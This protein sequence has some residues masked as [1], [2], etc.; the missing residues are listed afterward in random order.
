MRDL[1]V[2]DTSCLIALNK[3]ELLDILCKLYEK[4]FLPHMVIQEFGGK[5]D[6][7]CVEVIRAESPLRS[8]L[9]G[10]L[11]L[12]NGEAETIAYGYEKKV[13]IVIDDLKA[14]KVAEKLGLKVTGT[15]GILYKAQK[16]G[17]ITSAYK[18]TVKLKRKGFRV[19]DEILSKLKE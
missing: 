15:I 18:E 6:L 5:P 16:R 12:G 1:A 7:N 11:N 13:R 4:I 8:L 14:R 19:S 9:T 17:L 2:V 3:I 10:E